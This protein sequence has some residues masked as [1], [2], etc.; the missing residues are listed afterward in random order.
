MFTDIVGYTAMMHHDEDE[1]IALV[2]R[3][4]E[5]LEACVTA[6]RGEV[7]QYYGDGSLT[8][9]NSAIEAL[10]CALEIQQKLREEPHVPLRIGIHTGEIRMEEKKAYGDVINLA[11]RI[12]SIGQEGTVLFSG[13]V[14]EN[15]RNHPE[16]KA[17]S[18]GKF[19]F[20]NVDEPMEV[21]A[22]ANET[23]PIPRREEMEGKLKPLKAGTATQSRFW[24]MGAL[25][26]AIGLLAALGYWR[27]N[28]LAVVP[29]PSSIREARIAVMPYQNNTNDPDLDMVGEMAADWIIQ[30]MMNLEN[31]QVVSYQTIKDVTQHTGTIREMKFR[32]IFQRQTGAQK[33]IRGTYYRQGEDLIFQSQIID[34][35][36]G[37]VEFVLPEI[38]GTHTEVMDLVNELRQRV[39]G[40]FIVV[41]DKILLLEHKPPKYEAYKAYLEAYSY[42]GADY[43]QSRKLCGQ[44]IAID[45]S[46]LWPYLTMA[47]SFYNQGNITALDSVI[48]LVNRRFKHLDEYERAYLAWAKTMSTAEL[49]DDY[50][51]MKPI[52]FRDPKNLRNNYLMGYST[53]M[54]NKPEETVSYFSMI[55]LADLQ[56]K[57]QAQTWWHLI[58]AY[59]LIRLDSLDKAA[60][61]LSK[62][63]KELASLGY[64]YRR[65]DIYLLRG[66]EDSLQALVNKL[67]SSHLPDEMISN[68]YVYISIQYKMK[69]DTDRHRKWSGLAID[70]IRSQS[71]L[72]SARDEMLAGTYYFTDDYIKAL[73]YYSE[74][75]RT[76]STAWY[77][78]ARIGC[79]YARLGEVDQAAEII[80]RLQGLDSPQTIGQYR[81]AMALVYSTLGEKEKAV[82]HMKQAF[83]A[84][85]GFTSS[86]YKDAFEFLPLSGYPPF[87][88]FVAPNG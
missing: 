7:L 2:K 55:D 84:G 9:F 76:G 46:F 57:Y 16:F 43:D 81:Y 58:Y 56:V 52:F 51:L 35:A 3:H 13:E 77:D 32:Q 19:D 30:G 68:L 49:Q 41:K 18:L 87:E 11:S 29:L 82:A 62:V 54:L 27:I 8:I 45:S 75:L 23:F 47:G 37:N 22:L 33:V 42:F 59:N 69:E 64:Y 17:V 25:V 31:V 26:S 4:Q 63:P 79:I 24:K 66:Q 74:R 48:A 10:R 83:R 67:E 86:R 6:H 80:N 61:V 44:A 28:R 50:Q 72:Q 15:I 12:E 14:F 65:A 60:Y 88:E 40:Y 5:V 21:F 34:M 1:A 36:S 20:K 73:P 85:F 39:L 71:G 78:L 38:T 70:K 53:S